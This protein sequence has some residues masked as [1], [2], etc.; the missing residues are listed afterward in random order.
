MYAGCSCARSKLEGARENVY[1]RQV[2]YQ[3]SLETCT[4][5]LKSVA[6][7]VLELLA[8]NAQ[9]LGSHMTLATPPFR[10]FLRIHARSPRTVPGNM[11]IEFEVR[12]FNRFKQVRLT[13]PLRTRTQTNTRTHTHTHRTKTVSPP[14]HFVHLAEIIRQTSAHSKQTHLPISDGLVE[15]LTDCLT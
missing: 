11:H 6:L 8:F 7:T 4:S 9:N 12:S 15:W 13:G 2:N 5:N 10:I 1:L 14:I 3:L